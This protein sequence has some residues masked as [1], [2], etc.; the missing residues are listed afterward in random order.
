[1]SRNHPD[2]RK[3]GSVNGLFAYP[4]FFICNYRGMSADASAR[5][6]IAAEPDYFVQECEPGGFFLSDHP[7]ALH[8]CPTKDQFPRYANMDRIRPIIWSGANGFSRYSTAPA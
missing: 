3:Q 1:M 6:L 8:A 4:L 5:K 2:E 7:E